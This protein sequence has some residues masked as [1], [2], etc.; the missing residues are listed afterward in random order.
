MYL[1]ISFL[2]EGVRLSNVSFAS[3]SPFKAW[4]SFGCGSITLSMGSNSTV[5]S[6]T[7]PILLG[8]LL[9]ILVLIYSRHWPLYFTSVCRYG[10]PLIVPL[11]GIAPLSF[12]ACLKI[13]CSTSSGMETN[14]FIPIISISAEKIDVLI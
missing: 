1:T 7:S 2:R 14:G 9:S 13:T 11:T 4:V 12:C 10:S 6:T 3:R 5:S 8:E